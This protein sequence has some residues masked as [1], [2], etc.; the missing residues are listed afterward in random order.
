MPP[1][2]GD[3]VVYHREIV[4]SF[5]WFDCFPRDRRQHGVQVHSSQPRIGA[6]HVSEIGGAGVQ[7]LSAED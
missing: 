3:E 2:A 7:Q 5:L 6:F 1:R 4:G